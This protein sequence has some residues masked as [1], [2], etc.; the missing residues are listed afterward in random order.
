MDAFLRLQRRLDALSRD[1]TASGSGG[2]SGG[3]STGASG[4]VASVSTDAPGFLFDKLTTDSTLTKALVGDAGS[5]RVRLSVAPGGSVPFGS[6]AIALGAVAADGVA[7]TVI[8][9]DATIAAFDATTPAAEAFG[10]SG[11]AGS[12]AFAARRD[13]VH[14]MPAS[15]SVPSAASTVTGPDAFGAAAIVGAS[16]AFA[17]AD[18]D[19]GLP[20]ASGGMTNP[21]TTQDDI[22]VGGASG[23]PGRLAKGSDGQVL[24]VD[25]TTHHLLWATPSGSVPVTTK[26]DLLGFSTVAA[27]VPIGT[28]ASVL[29][30]DSTQALGLK[31]AASASGFADP[32][33]TKGDLINKIA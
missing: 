14:A 29:T 30:A 10:A 16:G 22:I 26:G 12:A 24:T 23:V 31:W 7:A 4:R 5:Q 8:R 33:T 15:P 3:S 17:R 21:M 32:T 6:P 18:H 20:A 28:D 11:A 9:S 2:G 25:P 19:H 27:R 13:H 1:S